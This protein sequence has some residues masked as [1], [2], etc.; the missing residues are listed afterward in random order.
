MAKADIWSMLLQPQVPQD[1]PPVPMVA[2]TAPVDVMGPIQTGV[3]NAKQELKKTTHQQ[4]FA[5][6]FQDQFDITHKQS[7]DDRKATLDQLR[8]Q[9]QQMQGN[10]PTAFER[11]D[12]TSALAF[13][14][15]LTGG[16]SAAYYRGPQKAKKYDEQVE[17]LQALINKEAGGITDDEL[18]YLKLKSQ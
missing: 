10:A 14:D 7:V 18:N 17:K 6:S 11:A 13:A 4:L 3:P 8:G 5:P 2:S 9:L 15:S 16:N 12:L 1:L